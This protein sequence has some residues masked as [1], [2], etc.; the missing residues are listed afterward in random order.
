MAHQG[1]VHQHL[2]VAG[3]GTGTANFAANHSGAVVY[4]KISV[5]SGQNSV[6]LHHMTMYIEGP[7]NFD[8]DTFGSLAA[9]TNGINVQIVSGTTVKFDLS[10]GEP[11]K[12]NGQAMHIAS[13]FEF[14]EK[15][16]TGN[17]SLSYHWD[18]DSTL[19]FPLRLCG[20]NEH[21]LRV[22]INDDLS[23][24]TSLEFTATGHLTQVC[25]GLP[26]T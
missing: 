15:R 22:S 5:P 1:L 17:S 9:L 19:G 13:N 18:F 10:V 25:N 16:G 24:L 7:G 11:I 20:R 12:S 26:T 4:P 8:A 23:A 21:A 2:T 14:F 6:E 3:D